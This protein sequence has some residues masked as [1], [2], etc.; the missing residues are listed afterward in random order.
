MNINDATNFDANPLL[1]EDGTYSISWDMG[2]GNYSNFLWE[3]KIF[4][5]LAR[6]V[7]VSEVSA[8]HKALILHPLEF[9]IS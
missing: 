2:E 5:Y 8:L 6:C 1:N 7:N 4:G 9:F 3:G